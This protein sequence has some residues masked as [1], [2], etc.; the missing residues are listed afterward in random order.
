MILNAIFTPEESVTEPLVSENAEPMNSVRTLISIC[1]IVEFVSVSVHAVQKSVSN[2][3]V[4]SSIAVSAMYAAYPVASDGSAS[5]GGGGRV[6]VRST[7]DT[8]SF[9]SSVCNSTVHIS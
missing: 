2:W 5:L 8:E 6:Q 7:P 1:A 9:E 3:R 4:R